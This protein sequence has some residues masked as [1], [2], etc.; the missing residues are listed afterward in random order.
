[1]R[2]VVA[3][4]NTFEESIEFR[5]VCFESMHFFLSL[6]L[7]CLIYSTF[8]SICSPHFLL[9]LYLVN[10]K[11]IYVSYFP[12][13]AHGKDLSVDSSK[14]K[15]LERELLHTLH[16]TTL[17]LSSLIS[18]WIELNQLLLTLPYACT[19]K[20]IQITQ[21]HTLLLLHFFS[22]RGRKKQHRRLSKIYNMCVLVR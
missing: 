10:F 11:R 7:F 1:M 2:F 6:W 19:I 13:I 4:Y 3:V 5:W 17:R 15:P 12:K 16:H 18:S 8:C 14:S 21:E 22:R 20:H 9:S